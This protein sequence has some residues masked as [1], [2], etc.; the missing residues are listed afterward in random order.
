[1]P[2]SLQVHQAG[3]ST[4]AGR[5][6]L[7]AQ[8]M[9]LATIEPASGGPSLAAGAAVCHAVS[10]YPWRQ[11]LQPPPSKRSAST[12]ASAA[13]APATDCACASRKQASGWFGW[14][15][16]ARHDS[17]AEHAGPSELAAAACTCPSGC[18]DADCCCN[19]GPRRRQLGS[20][21][22]MEWGAHGEAGT[23]A[24]SAGWEASWRSAAQHGVARGRGAAEAAPLL[25]GPGSMQVLRAP[26]HGGLHSWAALPGAA[27]A[28]AASQQQAQQHGQEEGLSNEEVREGVL[29]AETFLTPPADGSKM[30]QQ[31]QQIVVDAA[32]VEAVLGP[33]RYE[34]HNNAGGHGHQFLACVR[35]RFSEP[36]QAPPVLPAET[37]CKRRRSQRFPAP[38]CQPQL[39]TS[40]APARVQSACR[41]PA[42]PRGWC[43]PQ[44]AARCSTLSASA[45]ARAALVDPAS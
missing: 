10:G 41:P 44:L 30:Q 16:W 7:W 4:P 17:H 20:G 23:A 15:R 6:R 18:D 8:L 38:S 42:L 36:V 26:D 45:W 37:R 13:A 3:A 22:A 1:M 11:L 40:P 25:C 34:G 31:Q 14:L 27:A 12:A 29:V 9:P 5:V 2:A 28:G 21:P 35:A 39:P 24:D 43:G 32:L 19:G 33:R